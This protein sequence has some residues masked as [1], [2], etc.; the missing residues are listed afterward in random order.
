MGGCPNVT[1]LTHLLFLYFYK[2][3]FPCFLI[4]LALLIITRS[5]GVFLAA[6]TGIDYLIRYRRLPDWRLMV[7]AAFIFLVPFIF[8]Y[9][10]YGD[11]FPQTGSAKIDQGKSGLWGETLIFLNAQYLIASGFAYSYVSFYFFTIFSAIG[12]AT[13]FKDRIAII[14]IIF[15]FL[16]LCFYTGLNIPSY[17]WYYAPFFYFILIFATHGFLK[18]SLYFCAKKYS[19]YGI[20]LVVLLCSVAAYSFWKTISFEVKGGVQYYEDAGIWIKQNTPENASIAMVE[21]GTV[22]WYSE[23]RVVDIL[24]LVNPY[25]ASYI[26]QRK[27]HNWLQHYQPD[28][29]LRHEPIWPHEQSISILEASGAYIP[30]QGFQVPGLILLKNSGKYSDKRIADIEY[31]FYEHIISEQVDTIERYIPENSPIIVLGDKENHIPKYFN[32]KNI[33][34]YDAWPGTDKILKKQMPGGILFCETGNIEK[35]KTNPMVKKNPTLFKLDGCYMWLPEMTFVQASIPCEGVIDFVES[36]NKLVVDGWLVV[37]SKDGVVPD[38]IFVTLT[39]DKN[40][41]INIPTLRMPRPDVG[42][43]FNQKTLLDS[44]FKINED[45]TGLTGDYNVNIAF[46]H[47]GKLEYCDQFNVPVHLNAQ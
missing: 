39:N 14:S 4:A 44:G 3:N 15:C 10:Y 20:I 46:V 29:I 42:A 40:E 17:H 6:V 41:K 25:N 13:L 7:I 18:V 43:H 37:S 35:I 31:L 11:F 28:Y 26:G 19:P 16:L 33:V 12:V 34:Y 45:V 36:K 47:K 1:P 27:F 8:N 24:G 22:G 30:E 38:D 5:E 21:I 9:F 23:R 32:R 2:I